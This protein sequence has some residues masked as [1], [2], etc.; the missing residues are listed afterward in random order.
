VLARGG[1]SEADLADQGL[2]YDLTVPLARFVAQHKE[3][4]RFFK[5][6]QIQPVWR[7]DRPGRGRLREFWQCDIDIIGSESTIAEAEVCGAICEVIARLGLDS[8]HLRLNHRALLRAII[9]HCGIDSHLEESAL[10]AVD[11][12]DKIGPSGVSEELIRRGVS[13]EAS[14]RLLDLLDPE[15]ERDNDAILNRLCSTIESDEGQAALACLQEVLE[16]LSATPAAGRVQMSP[17]LA[18]GLSYYTGPIFEIGVADLAGSL[19]GGGRYD[20]LVGMFLKESIPAVGFSLGL[21]RI[22]LLMEERDLYPNLAHQPDLLLCSVGIAPSH[23]L[24]VAHRLRA[25]SLRVEVY[26]PGAKL[27][28]QLQYAADQGVP[29]AAIVGENELAGKQVTL[30]D[31]TT[32][33]QN[34]VSVEEAGSHLKSY[35]S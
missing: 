19:G 23:A 17:E 13:R 27:K 15:G 16:L 10:V 21:E 22:L 34:T 11:K 26:P 29:Y 4:P 25:Q 9:S 7:A 8:F 14:R 24:Q 2:R 6:Y 3:L 32:G 28:K 35:Q 30:K 1:V 12:L 20:E 18:R 31:L 5:R 33:S